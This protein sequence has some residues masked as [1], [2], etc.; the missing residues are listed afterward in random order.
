MSSPETAI[1][2]SCFIQDY[3]FS[4]QVNKL[5]NLKYLQL[6]NLVSQ[7]LG[8]TEKFNDLL[9]SKISIALK[10]VYNLVNYSYRWLADIFIAL[11][12]S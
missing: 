5:S 6:G 8:S 11:F 7:T 1:S 3:Y 12:P 10:A 4:Y 2:L 9:I